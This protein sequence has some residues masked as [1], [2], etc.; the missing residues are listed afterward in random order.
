[1]TAGLLRAGVVAGK[2]GRLRSRR[3]A[4]LWCV[5]YALWWLWQPV[6]AQPPTQTQAQQAQEQIAIEAA[7]K[8][9]RQQTERLEIINPQQAIATYKSFYEERGH[10]SLEVAIDLSSRIAQLYWRELGNRAKAQEIY[11][12]A[13]AQYGTLKGGERLLKERALLTGESALTMGPVAPG[14]GQIPGKNGAGSVLAVP[15]VVLS[16]PQAPM[17][18]EIKGA[19]STAAL[20][21]L[22]TGALPAEAVWAEGALTLDDVVAA[23]EQRRLFE[24][25]TKAR[26]A[27]GLV[28][29]LVRHGQERWLPQPSASASPSQALPP[30]KPLNMRVRLAVADYLSNAGDER[31]VAVYEEMLRELERTKAQRPPDR[32]VGAVNHLAGHYARRGQLQKALE[33][34]L[35]GEKYSDSPYWHA[36]IRVDAARLYQQMGDEKKAQELYAQVPRYG[37]GWLTTLALWDQAQELIGQQKYEEARHLLSQPVTGSEAEEM[38]VVLLQLQGYCAYRS[39][40]LDAARQAYE[41]C[42]ARF[43]TLGR[44]RNATAGGRVRLAREGLRWIERWTQAKSQLLCEPQE[45]HVVVDTKQQPA[46]P[47]VRRFSVR[48]LRSIPLQVTADHALVK[49]RPLNEKPPLDYGFYFQKTMKVEI[50]PEALQPETLQKDVTATPRPFTL[51]ISSPELPGLQVRVPIQIEIKP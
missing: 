49:V 11:D 19:R 31:A 28:E 36:T 27:T 22:E 45:L 46:Q 37:A 12:W 1:M 41:E 50:A 39:G 51:T 16:L 18:V 10:R 2:R 3:G 32:V 15:P 44:T 20:M 24:D 14:G 13:V 47:I 25:P 9:L 48:T 35:S 43:Q 23:S 5:F 33:T 17:P 7:W 29:L 6:G 30:P 38:Q 34:F 42:V 26:L 8:A 21:Q 40:A 4:F